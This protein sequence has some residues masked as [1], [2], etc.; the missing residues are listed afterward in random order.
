MKEVNVDVAVMGAGTAG[1]AAYRAACETGVRT[2][3]IESGEFGTTCA[4]VGC[5]PSKLLLAAANGLHDA[6]ASRR[7]ASKARMRKARMRLRLISAACLSTC[8]ANATTS[9][10]AS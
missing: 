5:I 4:R 10:T 2:V 7:A 8:D 9:S 1:M 6:R 3:L